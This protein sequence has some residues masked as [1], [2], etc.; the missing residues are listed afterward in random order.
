MLSQKPISKNYIINILFCLIPITYIAGNLVLNINILIFFMFFFGSF[1]LKI[2]QFKFNNI[3]K[4]VL[5]FFLYVLINGIINN[6]FNF[7]YKIEQNV[8]LYKTLA[9][10][11]FFILYFVLRYLIHNNLLNYKLIFLFF[12]AVALFVSLDIIYQF[13]FRIDFFGFEAPIGDRRLAG[14]FGDEWIAGSF[15]QRFFLFSIFYFLIFNKLKDNWKFHF[16][17]LLILFIISLGVIMSG[18]RIP[19]VMF[20]LSLVLLILFEKSLRKNLIIIFIIF[21]TSMYVFGKNNETLKLHY[22]S[23]VSKSIQVFDYFNEKY[24]P[25]RSGETRITN[26]Y[27]KEF[28]TGIATWKQNKMFGGGIKSFYYNCA[29]IGKVNANLAGCSSHPHNYYV[30]LAAELG[31]IGLLLIIILFLYIIIKT[32]SFIFYKNSFDEKKILIPFF[33]LFLVEIFPFRTT[34][35][36]FTTTT[37]TF[38]FIL[39][40]FIVGLTDLKKVK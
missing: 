31:L 32:L 19:A 11:R 12:G 36:F 5:I 24:N 6:Y 1:Q 9:Y 16:I 7:D 3:D 23:F 8:V 18:N 14:P 37:A 39:L 21:F 27:I 25:T 34:G 30:Q 33:I 20:F 35:S 10:L 38:L 22:S 29:K 26:T 13:F 28:E 17:S 40:P 2:F 4:F 15:I